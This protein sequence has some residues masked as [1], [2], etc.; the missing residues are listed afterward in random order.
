M[1]KATKQFWAAV[2]D[3]DIPSVK[4]LLDRHPE[5]VR[6]RYFGVAWKL[7]LIHI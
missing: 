1:S 6:E 3:D 7:S 4:T 5:L 2:A